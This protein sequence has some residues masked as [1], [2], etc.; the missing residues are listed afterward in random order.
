MPWVRSGES[1]TYAGRLKTGLRRLDRRLR[2][3]RVRRTALAFSA[4]LVVV[5][6]LLVAH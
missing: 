4:S 5:A 3:A 2:G 6:L 1:E